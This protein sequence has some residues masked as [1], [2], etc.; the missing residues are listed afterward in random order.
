MKFWKKKKVIRDNDCNGHKPCHQTDQ[1]YKFKRKVKIKTFAIGYQELY[2]GE[3]IKKY[4]NWRAHGKGKILKHGLSRNILYDGQFDNNKKHGH[5]TSYISNNRNIYY[6]GYSK[7]ID[8]IYIGSFSNDVKSGRGKLFD[9]DGQLLCKG[10]WTIDKFSYGCYFVYSGKTILRKYKGDFLGENIVD[11]KL[12][13]N[14]KLIYEGEFK[15]F[16]PHGKGIYYFPNGEKYVGQFK[17]RNVYNKSI[18]FKIDPNFHG[19]GTFYDKNG[20][21]IYEGNW[22][23][24]KYNGEGT[25]Y[26]AKQKVKH[27]GIFEHGI[28]RFDGETYADK[29]CGFGREYYQNGNLKYEGM[30]I[31]NVPHGGY[32]IIYHDTNIPSKIG[33]FENG[34]LNGTGAIFD[35]NGIILKKGKFIDGVLNGFAILYENGLIKYKGYSSNGIPRSYGME[36]VNGI[37]HKYKNYNTNQEYWP[38]NSTHKR[39]KKLEGKYIDINGIVDTIINMRKERI[40]SICDC[41]FSKGTIFE[42]SVHGKSKYGEKFVNDD[43]NL[44]LIQMV[45]LLISNDQLCGSNISHRSRGSSHKKE[46]PES[47]ES[48]TE[49]DSSSSS[50]SP[51]HSP[52]SSPTLSLKNKQTKE[53][54]KSTI[55]GAKDSINGKNEDIIENR[56]DHNI[57]DNIEENHMDKVGNKLGIEITPSAIDFLSDSM[58]TDYLNEISN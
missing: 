35:E 40:E 2:H 55:D 20:R 22:K 14:D 50:N 16:I 13:E 28:F 27:F 56:I 24:N 15:Y 52:F 44:L 43:E 49:L 3:A 7:K 58:S 29:I 21:M 37:L 1:T 6:D 54:S 17:K 5:G 33:K 34:Q 41:K 23:S 38:E 36:F 51:Q 48:L 42:C 12:Y 26:D 30:M 31:E 47:P 45:K 53:S 11:G 32:G 18:E 39:F 25:L 10:L 19:N 57:K 9:I 4:G 8:R 46:S